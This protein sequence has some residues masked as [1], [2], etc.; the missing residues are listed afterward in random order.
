M[1][2]APD[3]TPIPADEPAATAGELRALLGV[4][5]STLRSW[6]RRGHVRR[7]GELRYVVSDVLRRMARK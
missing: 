6:A 1:D 2:N 5:A 4:P 7:V 3:G